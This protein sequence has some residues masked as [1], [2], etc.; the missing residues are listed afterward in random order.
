LHALLHVVLELSGLGL[1]LLILCDL[2]FDLFLKLALHGLDSLDTLITVGLELGDLSVESLLVV[3][4]L[5][6]VLALNDLLGLL[7]DSV[8]LHVLGPLLK[9]S[10][11]TLETF[12]FVHDLL[13]HSL[14]A[15]N[16][17]HVGDLGVTL[18]LD[19]T[20]LQVDILLQDQDSVLIVSGDWQLR[21]FDLT[22]LEVDNDLEVVL[23]FLDSALGLAL[24][25]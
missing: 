18:T 10:D 12:V 22:L 7:G 1:E 17:G 15:E 20:V 24:L 5:L 13:E 11:L 2:F 6:D 19:E 9:V 16:V 14:V 21:N 3:L 25:D 23:E 8:Q 4:L